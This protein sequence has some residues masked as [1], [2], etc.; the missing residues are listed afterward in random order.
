MHKTEADNQARPRQ[1]HVGRGQAKRF[2]GLAFVAFVG[3]CLLGFPIYSRRPYTCAVCRMDRV[4]QGCLGLTW[5]SEK[6]TDCSRWYES[7]VERAHVHSWV[8]GTHCRR[9]GIPGLYGGYGCRIGGP[10]TGLSR[11]VQIEIYRHFEDRLEAKRLFIRLGQMDGDCYRTF[12]ALMEWVGH[13]YPGK[14]HDW[15]EEHGENGED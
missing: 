8:E 14:W 12:H 15:L 2:L 6:E 7:N 10:L 9:F 5:S 3:S 1:V 4:D 13:D 11:T